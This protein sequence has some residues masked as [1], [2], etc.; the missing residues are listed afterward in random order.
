ME[1][2]C[3]GTH[4]W[5]FF[6]AG[7]IDQVRLDR[8]NDLMALDQLDQKLWMALACP[9]AG[10]HFDAQTLAYID[11]DGDGRVRAPELIAAV[12]WAGGL[13]K[14][15][16]DLLKGAVALPLDAIDDSQP[17]GVRLVQSARR[18]LANLGKPEATV[19]ETADTEDLSR[20][21]QTPFNGDGIIPV[22]AASDP[23]TGAVIEAII[24]AMGS[25]EDRSGE[26]GIDQELTDA[27]F[28]EAEAFSQW[29][30]KAEADAAV[31]PLGDKTAA[32]C[33]AVR[34]VAAKVEDYFTRCRLSAFDTRA[35]KALNREE[36]AYLELA[37]Q[38]LT[39][40]SA[41]IAALPLARIE[42]GQP[43]PLG[44][45]LNPAW[46]E[47]ITLLRDAAVAPLLGPDTAALS[48]AQWR[49]LLAR[50]APFEAW[51]KEKTGTAVEGLGLER[52]RQ[53][54][55][56][57]VR[58][59]LSELIARD[60]AE[61]ENADAITDVDKLVRFHRDLHR[62]CVNFVNFKDFYDYGQAAVFQAGILYLDQ[63]SCE[64]CLP[65][66]DAA[67]HAALAALAGACLV[68]C[69]CT[70][71]ADGAK[72]QIAAVFTD[73]DSDN[74]M[75]GRNGIFYDRQG[76]DWDATVT[77][78]VDNPISLRQAFWSPYKKLVRLIEEQVA[79]R[80]GAADAAAS[81]RLQA[82]ATKVATADQPQAKP[83]E[84][85]KKPDIA[86]VAAIGVAFGAIG[87]FLATLLA[88]VTGVI[89]MGPLAVLGAIVAIMLVIS[90]PSLIMAWLKLRK[91]NLGPLLD[92]NGWAI[93]ARARISVALGSIL[94]KIARLP[95][96]AT[97][98]ARDP[99]A[100]K[101][102]PWP[103]LIVLLLLLSLVYMALNHMGYIHQWT[104]GRWGQARPAVVETAVPP[105]PPAAPQPAAAP[106]P[107]PAPAPVK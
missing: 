8:G 26:P 101:K 24:A 36:T 33:D 16:D 13:L 68:Y 20:V 67:K 41:E 70:R 52:V 83:P 62:L 88:Y 17:A 79:K 86:T 14:N 63:R 37:A 60:A 23:E 94:T 3:I 73:G 27:F 48:E 2:R 30:A 102:S 38:D 95:E 81:A 56:S 42:A 99:Y 47:A 59:T 105:A 90:G 1:E 19:I 6:R 85:P 50:I 97:R 98:D 25:R 5:R 69:D 80:L 44:D 35:T 7:G 34:A 106:S 54:L 104:G 76:R 91:R 15:P 18:I 46:A 39:I 107:A 78:I 53:I 75:V 31:L 9:T 12:R 100:D 43:L 65:V 64:L 28:A 72:M 55:A 51:S 49:D 82:T 66:A 71:Q 84:P 10:L 61:A 92:A 103:T 45:G 40:T 96:G 29:H 22:A 11:T 4:N 93:N 87:T 77:K 57:P 89:K 58:A 32:A 74:L 21:F